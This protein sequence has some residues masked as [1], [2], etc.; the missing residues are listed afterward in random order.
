MHVV[1]TAGGTASIAA[2][3]DAFRRL[4]WVLPA[5]WPLVPILYVPGV[6]ALGRRVYR[7]I[8]SHRST[9]CSLPAARPRQEPEELD[10]VPA[11]R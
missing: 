10:G 4:A 3:F 7:W 9:H 6:P 11:T 8:A 2:G 5:A 1:D